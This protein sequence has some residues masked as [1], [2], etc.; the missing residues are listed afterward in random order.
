MCTWLLASC[1]AAAV[2]ARRLER[3]AIGPLDRN[4]AVACAGQ[5]WP[6]DRTMGRGPHAW[7]A[8]A[9]ASARTQ[10]G[11]AASIAQPHVLQVNC[12]VLEYPVP[13]LAQKAKVSGSGGA[14]LTR[15]VSDQIR[16]GA[17]S[18]E[19]EVEMAVV[20]AAAARISRLYL[21]ACFFM[22]LV[23]A[24]HSAAGIFST[25]VMPFFL[26]SGVSSQS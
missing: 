17:W 16:S 5:Q 21:W 8:P 24:C 14:S 6:L 10:S 2:A 26:L 13:Q 9:P 1:R 20:A 25:K 15:S 18:A 7:S 23:C 19:V 4:L 12:P 11:G 22:W 3:D